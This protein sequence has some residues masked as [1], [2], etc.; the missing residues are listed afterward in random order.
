MDDD[1]WKRLHKKA[2][3]HIRG[4]LDDRVFHHMFN[5]TIARELWKKLE[6]RYEQKTATNKVS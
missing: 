2:I 4:W 1:A 3:A 5:E 6:V